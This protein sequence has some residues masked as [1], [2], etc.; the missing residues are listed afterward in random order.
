MYFDLILFEILEMKQRIS[1]IIVSLESIS[2]VPESSAGCQQNVIISGIW[3]CDLIHTINCDPLVIIEWSF[4]LWYIGRSVNGLR[5]RPVDELIIFLKE[6]SC[7]GFAGYIHWSAMDGYHLAH[8]PTS[9][10]KKYIYEE[11]L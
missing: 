9:A 1:M 3:I 8:A 4:M 11:H 5:L 2:A 10:D 6:P 7:H